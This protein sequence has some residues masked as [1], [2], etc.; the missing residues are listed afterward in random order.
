[1]NE[2]DVLSEKNE[3]KARLLN[4]K[5]YNSKL[6]Y[7]ASLKNSNENLSD[8]ACSSSS[9]A[10]NKSFSSRKNEPDL[11]NTS[12]FT[13]NTPEEEDTT[14]SKGNFSALDTYADVA[15]NRHTVAAVERGEEGVES[16]KKYQT[17]KVLTPAE[18]SLFLKNTQYVNFPSR[19]F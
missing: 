3:E 12:I 15:D 16:R 13:W 2:V 8:D 5:P 6:K 14:S 9:V 11:R 10:K 18:S 19:T 1:M 17:P 7:S 4:L